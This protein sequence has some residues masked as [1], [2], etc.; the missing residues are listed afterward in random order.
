M[1]HRAQD[2]SATDQL[3]ILT[4]ESQVKM[5]VNDDSNVS[6]IESG[7]TL[8]QSGKRKGLLGAFSS[9]HLSHDV[10]K[11]SFSEPGEQD[12]PK[13]LLFYDQSVMRCLLGSWSPERCCGHGGYLI[14]WL[15]PS[16]ASYSG[17]PFASCTACHPVHLVA[18]PSPASMSS[19]N[20]HEKPLNL[21]LACTSFMS[22]FTVITATN[23]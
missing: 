16:I 8:N 3:L 15:C 2:G 17:L 5:L 4:A 11:T 10:D 19:L 1:K 6:E 22:R 21:P 9:L 23:G 18:R 20:R 13:Y 12:T 14:A 7:V